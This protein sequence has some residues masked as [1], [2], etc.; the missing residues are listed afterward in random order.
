MITSTPKI[1]LVRGMLGVLW[2]LNLL[3]ASIGYAAELSSVAL[4]N[5]HQTLILGDGNISAWSFQSGEELWRV[6]GRGRPIQDI[7]FFSSDQWVIAIDGPDAVT[8]IYNGK[9]KL[10]SFFDYRFIQ[11]GH[12][13]ATTATAFNEGGGRLVVTDS[14]MGEIFLL[15]VFTFVERNFESNILLRDFEFE[16]F[17]P[18]V[19]TNLQVPKSSR[20]VLGRLRYEGRDWRDSWN[21]LAFCSKGERVVGV[22]KKGYLLVWDVGREQDVRG[23]WN[24]TFIRKLGSSKDPERSLNGVACSESG[25]IATVGAPGRFGV[26][27]IWNSECELEYFAQSPE[28]ASP[29]ETIDRVAFDRQG[30]YILSSGRAGYT[31]WYLTENAA[32]VSATLQP[33]DDTFQGQSGR[34]IIGLDDGKFILLS[35]DGAWLLDGKSRTLTRSFGPRP[36]ALKV[37]PGN[38][39]LQEGKYDPA[40]A[41]FNKAIE[42]DS[43][44]SMA[45]N[46]RGVAY[47]KKGQHDQAIADFNKAIEIDSKNSVAYNS[48]GFAYFWKGQ[49]DQAIAD[50]TKAIEIDS[51]NSMAYNNR[52]AA[53]LKKG[54]H[55]QA[56][57]D[58]N[59]A[60]E[61]NPKYFEAY[62][63]R[64][65]AYEDKGQYGKAIADH[66]KAIEIDSKN[67]VAY[68]NRGVAYLKK[69]QHD[70]AIADFNKAIEINPKYILYYQWRAMT[71][72][73]KMKLTQDNRSRQKLGKLICADLNK[74]CDLG[75]CAPYNESKKSG[76][77]N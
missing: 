42:I 48:R 57:A 34:P 6:E 7:S 40:I 71:Y 24:P 51:K 43:K 10:T 8:M 45:Y 2:Y 22:S 4:S 11:D 53:Y 38:A 54:Q 17:G 14:S 19:L 62:D 50:H 58:F 61:I 1:Q 46:D 26:L 20:A 23:A 67:S 65:R 66:T 75:E 68:N 25:R 70:Q 15:D 52:G 31:L 36:S 30:Q 3:C 13:T 72:D 76:H 41:D 5:D 9:N 39:Y 59:K 28:G 27:Q 44:N 55:D 77:C 35:G 12:P 33:D 37:N 69:G 32:V 64:G 63:N 56:I 49:H 16:G 60:I 74:I 21:D 73:Q 47:L 18:R 29:S